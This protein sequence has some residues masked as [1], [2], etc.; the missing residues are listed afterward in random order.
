MEITNIDEALRSKASRLADILREGGRTLLA[1]SGGVDSAYL[2]VAARDLLGEDL[3]AVLADSPSLADWEREEALEFART[4]GIPVRVLATRELDNPDYSRN[5]LDR[6]FH[7]K[8]ELFGR[9]EELAE[10]GGYETLIYGGNYSD[11]GDFRPGA[12]AARKFKVRAPLD[13]AGLVKDEIRALARERGLSVWDR[14]AR[15]CLASRIPHLEPVDAIK[16]DQLAR[17][18]K[19][20]RDLGFR[21]YRVRHHGQLARIELGG[22]EWGRLAEPELRDRVDAGIRS[23][24]FASI[25]LDLRPFVSGSLSRMGGA[26]EAKAKRSSGEGSA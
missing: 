7:C 18:E 17:A 6:C 15:A 22:E 19:Q 13:E 16:L 11:R 23:L 21:D 25:S 3:S 10:Q 12:D 14:P 8:S 24:G 4:H 26:A 1:Y 9:M 2:A 5:D 20:L